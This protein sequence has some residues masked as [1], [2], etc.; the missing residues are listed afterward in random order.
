MLASKTQ[1]IAVSVGKIETALDGQKDFLRYSVIAAVLWLGGITG[2]LATTKENAG[3]PYQTTVR[4]LEKSTNPKEVTANLELLTGQ[5]Q[6]QAISKKPPSDSELKQVGAAVSDLAKKYPEVPA[7]W[8]T[9]AQLVN[10][11]SDVKA[12][13]GHLPSCWKMP[14]MPS[15]FSPAGG[16]GGGGAISGDVTLAN[17]ELSLDDDE[18]FRN[19]NFGRTDLFLHAP[20]G[21]AQ[22]RLF[23]QNAVVTYKGTALIPFSILICRDCVFRMTSPSVT[24]PPNG[25][26]VLRQLLTADLDDVRLNL[27]V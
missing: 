14:F 6:K 5:I 7:V 13:P 3:A 11:R 21:K 2:Y 19:S 12:L 18:S 24:P 16:P 22:L 26:G 17:C 9:S 10:V 8:D 23:V 20:P 1:E 25:Q 15:N 4:S 27:G